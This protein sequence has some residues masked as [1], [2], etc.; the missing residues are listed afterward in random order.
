MAQLVL[1]LGYGGRTLADVPVRSGY[2]SL[3]N[4]GGFEC[5]EVFETSVVPQK[6]L[7]NF[8]R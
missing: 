5:I 4:V 8:V 7:E 2:S 3:N 6:Y 1:A